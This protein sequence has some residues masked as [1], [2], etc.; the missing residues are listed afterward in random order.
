MIGMLYRI[1]EFS[2]LSGVS[3]KTLRHYERMGLLIAEPFVEVSYEMPCRSFY[4]VKEL[5]AVM[6]ACA[7]SGTD[8]AAADQAYHAIN[9][10]MSARGFS[11]AGPRR[12]IHLDGMLE[13]QFPLRSE[14]Q[15]VC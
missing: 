12:E 6:T 2:A 8:D 14:T 10:W 5:P 15:S 9:M 11:L 3:T 13:I 7:F 4:D 1:G